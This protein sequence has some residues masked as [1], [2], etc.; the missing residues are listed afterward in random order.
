MQEIGLRLGAIVHSDQ[1]DKYVL[2]DF[3]N[4]EDLAWVLDAK[5]TERDGRPYIGG[6]GTNLFVMPYTG[7]NLE[8][9]LPNA[10]VAGDSVIVETKQPSEGATYK[11]LFARLNNPKTV[12]VEMY[13]LEMSTDYLSS[14]GLDV[15][16]SVG[17]SIDSRH[18]G[19]ASIGARFD[20]SLISERV[21]SD[22]VT[23][24]YQEAV[25]ISGR[26]LVASVEDTIYDDD[27]VIA[28]E[29]VVTTSQ[30]ARSRKQGLRLTLL[31]YWSDDKWVGE[32]TYRDGRRVTDR[33]DTGVDYQL[34]IVVREGESVE[35]RYNRFAKINTDSRRWRWFKRRDNTRADRVLI[36]G[37]RLK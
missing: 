17:G 37:V 2:G 31:M 25:A 28:Q 13:A 32:L 18:P 21:G 8:R 26:P 35:A 15:N 34:P 20:V 29:G 12:A 4:A 6:S 16:G 33:K 27:V 1:Q 22:G 11:Q 36:I 14:L 24:L 3:R 30:A 5:Y 7:L 19:A 10:R 23:G 9:V